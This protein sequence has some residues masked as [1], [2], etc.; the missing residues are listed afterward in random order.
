MAT[1][2]G[3]VLLEERVGLLADRIPS[4][5]ESGRAARTASIPGVGPDRHRLVAIAVAVDGRTGGV[6]A[7][8]AGED[9]GTERVV[10]IRPEVGD[11]E[12]AERQGCRIL[13]VAGDGAGAWIETSRH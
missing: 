6:A 4:G 11:L 12:V 13:A 8:V 1:V 7:V 3:V 9:P 5:L 10:E 2:L